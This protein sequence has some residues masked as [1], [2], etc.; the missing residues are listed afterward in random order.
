[1][2]EC[3]RRGVE[4]GG[5][6]EAFVRAVDGDLFGTQS[7]DGE[8]LDGLTPA[9]CARIMDAW[10]KFAALGGIGP[11]LFFF[12]QDYAQP[13]VPSDELML[14]MSLLY[15]LDDE[16]RV[17]E[18][19]GL[20]AII[21]DITGSAFVA[22]LRF[23]IKLNN[24]WKA[25]VEKLQDL[26]VPILDAAGQLLDDLTGGLLTEL[27]DLFTQLKDDLMVLIAEEALSSQDIFAFF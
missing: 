26:I 19:E 25:F 4:D 7:L 20:L 27:G 15:W 1:V 23:L 24:L 2:V 13:Q 14:A 5:V 16:G 21:G 18:W 3:R 17:D 8:M 11:D 10:P 6:S 12:L 22:L 9:E